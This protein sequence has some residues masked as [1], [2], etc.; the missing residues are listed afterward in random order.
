MN[1]V[2]PEWAAL[3]T[4]IRDDQLAHPS[5][6]FSS[7]LD[8]SSAALFELRCPPVRFFYAAFLTFEDFAGLILGSIVSLSPMECS[9]VKM[10]LISGLPFLDS[11]R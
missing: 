1:E 10:L 11:I 5:A 4:L 8:V 2:D 9:K 3:G 6:V 7:D